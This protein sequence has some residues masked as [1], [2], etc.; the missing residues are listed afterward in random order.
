MLIASDKYD[1]LATA[2]MLN[3]F[4]IQVIKEIYFTFRS[5]KDITLS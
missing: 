3:D 4:I 2:Q 1:S 5:W